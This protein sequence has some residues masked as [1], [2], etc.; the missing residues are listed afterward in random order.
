V[1]LVA[2]LTKERECLLEMLDRNGDAPVW[3]SASAEV[4]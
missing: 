1:G 2:D 3:T 4:C